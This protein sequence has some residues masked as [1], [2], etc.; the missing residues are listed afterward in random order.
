[1]LSEE[2]TGCHLARVEFGVE[3]LRVLRQRRRE[4]HHFELQRQP[5]N[6]LRRERTLQ[7]VDELHIA[8]DVHWLY[9]I[10]IVDGFE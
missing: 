8:I 5:R 7:H 10:G 1:M 9:N 6:E 4:H 3:R 2:E